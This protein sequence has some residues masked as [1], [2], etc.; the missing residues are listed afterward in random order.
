MIIEGPIDK[1]PPGKETKKLGE[2]RLFKNHLYTYVY[3]IHIGFELVDANKFVEHAYINI[4]KMC[5]C[6]FKRY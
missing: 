3:A 2:K 6:R 5:N 1:K 4:Q